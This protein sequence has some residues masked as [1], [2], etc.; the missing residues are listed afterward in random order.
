MPTFTTPEPISAT[1]E[2]GLGDIRITAGDRTDTVVEVRPSNTSA[3]ADVRAAEETRVEYADGRLLIKG[4]KQRGFGLF[5]KPGSIDVTVGLPAGSH[6]RGDAS[7][8]A[9]HCAGRLG[10]CRFKTAAGDV[11]LGHTG[12]LELSTAAG[13]VSVDHV[14]GRAEISSGT[15]RVRLRE[16]DGAAEIRN[17]NGDS[18]I[19]RI[20]GD[21][22]VKA[23]N[24]DI[25]VDEAQADVNA[26][27]ANG[28]VRI[29][30]IRRGAV[31]VKSACGAL[32]IGVRAGTAAKLDLHT[33]FG[34]VLNRLEASDAPG[35]GD[36]TVEVLARTSYGDIVI[37]RG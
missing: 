37:H 22:R 2:V 26:T 11:N 21:L 5:G 16:I 19:G 27:T 24:G 7:V 4:P 8:A 32:E 9:F 33:Q 30:A 18:W 1:I 17:A 13:A 3:E 28:D 14:A 6:V 20:T 10:D 15:G 34:S 35:Q 31:S 29:G 36:E 12:T 23:A 25:V